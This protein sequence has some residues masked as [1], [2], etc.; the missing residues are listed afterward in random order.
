MAKWYIGTMGF[1]YPD[2]KGVY[3]PA[4]LE[5]RDYIN[6]YSQKFPAV[7]VDSTFYGIPRD[8]IVLRWEAITT[9]EFKICAKTPQTITHESGLKKNAKDEMREFVDR[10]RLLGR[11]LGIILIQF[12][13]SFTPDQFDALSEFLAD[14]PPGARY[15]VEFRDQSWYTAKTEGLLREREVCWTATEYGRTSRKVALTTDFMYVRLIG[16]HGRFRQHDREQTD[17]S[18]QLEWWRIY[19]GE[20][21]KLVDE[22]YVFINNDFSGHAP[23]TARK[24]MEM[25]SSLDE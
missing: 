10:M 18:Q 12:P 2:W 20:T 8:S 17:I 15:A 23:A 16:Q 21:S 5:A 19:L 1:S 7:E 14:L 22:I 25:V 24:F 9:D 13:P 3:Y 6:F 4:N 11:K